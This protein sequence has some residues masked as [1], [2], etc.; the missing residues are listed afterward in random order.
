MAPRSETAVTAL[1]EAPPD[2][3]PGTLRDVLFTD[4]VREGATWSHVL[5]RGTALRITDPTGRANVAAMF[6]NW[7][8]P[9]ERY[10]MPDTLKAQHTAR[11]AAG[12]VLYSDMGRILCSITHDSLGWHDPLSGV[13]NAALVAAKYGEGSYQRLRNAW[14]RNAHDSFVIELAKYG[15]SARDMV[16][17]VNFFSKVV[18]DASGAMRF[19]PGHSS[20]G[21]AIEL[22]AEMPVLVILNTCQHPMDPHPSY[23]PQAV[24]LAVRRVPPPAADDRCRVSC[25]EN[26]RGFTLTERYAL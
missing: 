2:V 18:V 9:T 25:P 23:D 14:H 20:P 26:G 7:E 6:Y 8:N 11:L 24:D 5:K 12:H 22:R 10:N 3:T 16:A 21:A 1:A 19:V 17:P 13:G 4:V 15:L